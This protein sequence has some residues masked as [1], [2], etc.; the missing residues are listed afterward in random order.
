M[1]ISSQNQKLFKIF[2]HISTFYTTC[3]EVYTMVYL[4]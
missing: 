2:Y 4:G 3:K 1:C